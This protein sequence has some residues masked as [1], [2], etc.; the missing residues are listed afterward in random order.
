MKQGFLKYLIDKDIHLIIIYVVIGFIVY[1][2]IKTL[3]DKTIS[4]KAGRNA[5]VKYD[6]ENIVILIG[7]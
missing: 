7:E 2:I 1:N 6:I 5:E 3:M 4:E